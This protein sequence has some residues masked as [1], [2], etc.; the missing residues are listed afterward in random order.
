MT[1]N[2]KGFA[3]KSL[4]LSIEKSVYLDLKWRE[5]KRKTWHITEER[6]LKE[7]TSEKP[8]LSLH[9][10]ADDEFCSEVSSGKNLN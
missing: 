6:F 8:N 3:I 5:R 2:S 1:L 7:M 10:S 9:I 4:F